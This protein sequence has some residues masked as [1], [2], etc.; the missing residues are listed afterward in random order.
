[1]SML[2]GLELQLE[3]A[4]NLVC[5][6]AGEIIPYDRGLVYFW[7]E[8]QQQ[9]HLRVARNLDNPDQETFDPRQSAQFLEHEV[10]KAADRSQR[11]A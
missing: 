2:A 11:S 4:L 9:M 5:D 6:M 3:P 10:P 8:E 1:M 7:D